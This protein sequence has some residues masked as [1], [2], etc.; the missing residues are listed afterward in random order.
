MPTVTAS[1]AAATPNAQIAAAM[2]S[3][4]GEALARVPMAADIVMPTRASNIGATVKEESRWNRPNP[5][6]NAPPSRRAPRR[7]GRRQSPNESDHDRGHAAPRRNEM[8]FLPLQPYDIAGRGDYLT[9]RRE[10]FRVI[11]RQG[12]TGFTA[13]SGQLSRPSRGRA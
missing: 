1:P 8:K 12:V 11:D 10:F 3:E 4:S 7:V 2:P 6:E 5:T 9:D 13:A